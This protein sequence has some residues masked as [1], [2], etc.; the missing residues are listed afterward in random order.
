MIAALPMYDWAETA[1]ANDALWCLIRDNLRQVGCDAPDHLTRS[2]NPWA[3][4]TDPRLVLAQTCGMPYRT[5]LHEK[6]TLVGT[7]DYGLTDTPFG[8]YYSVIVAR[9]DEGREVADLACGV[10]AMNDPLSQS[11]W[12]AIHA[13]ADA[14]GLAFNRVDVTGAHRDSAR[15][16]AEGRADLAAIDA[17]TWRLIKGHL[18]EISGKLRVVDRTAPTPGLPLITALPRDAKPVAEAVETAIA[19]LPEEA[20]EAIGITGLARIPA[21]TYLAVG[22]PPD[23]PAERA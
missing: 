20:R 10:L 12:A 1:P 21:K 8:H 6:V 7:P 13:H 11:G 4:W 18:P 3:I 15:A 23:P 5:H 14:L 17:V 16:V 9:T 2:I 19:D 22:N